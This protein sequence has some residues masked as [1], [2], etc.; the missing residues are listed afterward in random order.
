ME[1]DPTSF[2]G[3][4]AVRG[5]ELVPRA[6]GSFDVRCAAADRVVSGRLWGALSSERGLVGLAPAPFDGLFAWLGHA[7]AV[8]GLS[9]FAV[10][11]DADAD[12]LRAGVAL[13][14]TRGLRA[15]A[16]AGAGPAAAAA[17]AVGAEDPAARA[18]GLLSPASGDLPIESLGNRP[19]LFA[20]GDDDAP[21]RALA[22]RARGETRVWHFPLAPP[23]L[24][25]VAADLAAGWVPEL[26]KRLGRLPTHGRG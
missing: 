9:L 3:R 1:T 13:L 23:T 2:P 16:I 26:E 15:Y 21:T 19:C 4:P 25:E 12:A 7:L 6:D 20:C 11:G 10:R 14:R 18:V 5:A 22:G 8:R 17:L 24:A